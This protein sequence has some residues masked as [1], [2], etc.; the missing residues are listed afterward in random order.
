MQFLRLLS[1]PV[2]VSKRESERNRASQNH[3]FA[4]QL[5]N[6]HPTHEKRHDLHSSAH[7]YLKR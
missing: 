7:K 4:H 3:F 5:K 6:Q 1:T 2:P